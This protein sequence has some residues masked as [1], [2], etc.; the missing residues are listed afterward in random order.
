MQT[1]TDLPDRRLLLIIG[2]APKAAPHVLLFVHF[3]RAGSAE[4][5]SSE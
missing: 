2:D 1:W 5:R 3:R 4:S